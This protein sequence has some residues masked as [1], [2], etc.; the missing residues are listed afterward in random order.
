MLGNHLV[1]SIDT[2]GNVVSLICACAAFEGPG[3]VVG[4]ERILIS[5]KMLLLTF[6]ERVA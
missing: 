2:G 4:P 5:G 6:V 3:D 1:N